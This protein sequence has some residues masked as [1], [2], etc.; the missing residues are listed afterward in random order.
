V[1]KSSEHSPI[2]ESA[3]VRRQ[4]CAF[5]T[6]HQDGDDEGVLVLSQLP[7]ESEAETLR[8]YI[9]LRQTREVSPETI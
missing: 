8:H 4:L 3:I 9:G 2:S 5:T 6:V 7:N 1:A